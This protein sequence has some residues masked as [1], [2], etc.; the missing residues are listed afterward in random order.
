MK[1]LQI[2]IP[3]I[4]PGVPDDKDPCVQNFIKILREE[5]GVEDVHVSETKQNGVPQLCFHYNPTQI[6]ISRIRLIAKQAGSSITEKIG[7]KLIEVQGIRHTRHA[8]NIELALKNLPGM[9]EVSVSAAGMVRAEFEKKQLDESEIID[10]LKNEGLSIPDKSVDAERY[11]RSIKKGPA[12]HTE[13]ESSHQ[14]DHIHGGVFGYNTELIFSIISGILL[15]IGFVFFLVAGTPKWISISFYIGSYLFGGFFTTREALQRVSKGGFEVDFLMMVA[16]IGAAILGKWVEGALLL[17]LFSLGHALEHHAMNKAKKS[18]KAL[19]ELAPKTALRKQNGKTEEIDIDQVRVNDVIVVRPDSKIPVDAVVIYGQSSVDQSSI[20]GESIPIDKTPV[21]NTELDYSKENDI[22][23]ENRVYSG[24]INGNGSL[25]VK[26]IKESKDTTLSRLITLVNEAQTQKSPSQRFT[27]KFE[28]YFVPIILGLVV[29]LLGAFLVI[30]ETFTDS[31]YR[32]M[33]V[34][35]A[36]SPCALAISTPSAVL[37]GVARAAKG[38]VLIK[39]GRPLEDLGVLTAL[40]FDKTGTLTEGKPKLTEVIAF[41]DVT[42]IELLKI[43][44]AVESLSDH[45]LARAIVRDGTKRLN[46][47][48]FQEALDLESVLGKGIKATLGNDKVYIGNLILHESIDETKP[49]D[50]IRKEVQA[51]EEKG[52]TTMLVRLNN[53]FIGIIGLM[54]IP[55]PEAKSTLEQLKKVGIKRMIMLTGDN[56]SVAD[57]VANEIGITDAWGG[58]LPEEK[59]DAINKLKINES[60]VAMVGDGVN[61]APAMAHSTVGIA[62]GAASSAVALETADIALMGN[63]LDALPFAIGLSRKTRRIIKQNIW[64]SLGVVALLIPATI[65]GF[66]NM[67]VAVV[68]HEGSTLLVVFNALRLLRYKK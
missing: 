45:P 28:R 1:K 16:A 24:T 62:M 23:G 51:L 39:G 38:G 55:R 48:P 19:A 13:V 31:F 47:V 36:S 61:D 6:S 22:K 30:D 25:E 56:Q 3:H 17:F 8:R 26:V 60:K 46:G 53:T 68:I 50:A 15:A 43:A 4:L 41:D 11:L 34:L 42:E 63:T 33:T 9:I 66:A 54:D 57:A 35:V 32:A 12:K 65:F 2:D 64:I 27:D 10:A 21:E 37:S 14:H 49:S 67:A 40:A 58:L 7:H 20:T 18:I 59:V 5:K 52:N 29:L 44:V